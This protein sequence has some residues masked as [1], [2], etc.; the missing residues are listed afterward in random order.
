MVLW[1]KHEGAPKTVLTCNAAHTRVLQVNSSFA[2][3]RRLLNA[4]QHE[5]NKT[6]AGWEEVLFDAG[7]ATMETIVRCVPCYRADD[8]VLA[9]VCTHSTCHARAHTHTLAPLMPA[10]II[11]C[12]EN[13]LLVAGCWL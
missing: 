10:R 1:S 8:G 9:T 5:F 2:I 4:I 3:E 12:T 7:A 11:A 13:T 6:P